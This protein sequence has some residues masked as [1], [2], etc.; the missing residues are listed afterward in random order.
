MIFGNGIK[1]YGRMNLVPAAGDVSSPADGDVW[2]NSTT[3]RFRKRQNGVTSDLSQGYTI[4]VGGT[5]VA[6]PP[7][8][9]TY[10]VGPPS[11]SWMNNT[12]GRRR[13]YIKK[14]GTIT[15]A[16]LFMRIDGTAPSNEG[17]SIYIRLN[18]TTDTL[19]ATVGDTATE[20]R[21]A[22]AALSI[23]V[24]V[25]DYFEIKI[26]NPTW[27]TNPTSVIIGGTIYITE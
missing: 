8:G 11:A 2:Y 4:A 15:I 6:S 25:D 24:A 22:N 20:K 27:A 26:V 17:W 12:A 7:D 19:I 16:D 1:V 13:V 5:S 3:A 9:I 18:N 10:Y 21:F 23:A 14:P